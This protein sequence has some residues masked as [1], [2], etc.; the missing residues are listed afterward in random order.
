MPVAALCTLQVGAGKLCREQLVRGRRHVHEEL[1]KPELLAPK[2]DRAEKTC[3]EASLWGVKSS[4]LMS[5]SSGHLLSPY[6]C[7]SLANA[8]ALAGSGGDDKEFLCDCHWPFGIQA[9]R[10]SPPA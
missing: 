4:P 10:A 7:A 1:V 3:F 6:R 5:T 8:A 9:C 2:L